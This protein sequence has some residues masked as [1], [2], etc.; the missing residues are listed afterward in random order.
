[1][2]P[3]AWIRGR[4]A[5]ISVQVQKIEIY[6]DTHISRAGTAEVLQISI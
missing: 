2:L 4:N 5:R 3:Y 1:M 6:I